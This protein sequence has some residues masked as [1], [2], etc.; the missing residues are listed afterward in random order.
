MIDHS[1]HIKIYTGSLIAVH[2][3]KTL[4]EEIGVSSLV[5]NDV[6]GG[7]ITGMADFVEIYI[8]DEDLD[9]AKPII[10]KFL[11]IQESDK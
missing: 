11:K 7:V 3:L 8:L 1:K 6:E 9:K 10:D 4:L 2:H 5:Q